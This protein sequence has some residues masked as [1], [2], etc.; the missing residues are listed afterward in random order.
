[1]INNLSQKVL[2]IGIKIFLEFRTIKFLLIIVFKMKLKNE[3]PL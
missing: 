3:N 1:M 2:Q